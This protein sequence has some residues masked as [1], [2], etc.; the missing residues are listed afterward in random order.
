MEVI[1]CIWPNLPGVSC[2]CN[3]VVRASY[4]CV[5]GHR[6]DSIQGLRFFSL[7]HA[8]DM[9]NITYFFPY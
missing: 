2:T 4:W 1:H 8:H 6:F 5:E 7:S 9:V 3:S